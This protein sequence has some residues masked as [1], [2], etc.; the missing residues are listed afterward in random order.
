MRRLR[1]VAGLTRER[2]S[3]QTG[4]NAVTLYRIETGHARPQ[5]RTLTAMLDVYDLTDEQRANLIDLCKEATTHD[6]IALYRDELSNAYSAFISFE[7]EASAH[8]NYESLFLPGLLQTEDYARTLMQQT[9]RGLPTANA[10]EIRVKARMTRQML[11]TKDNPMSLWSVVDEAAMR[12]VV[13]G[14]TVM[15][16]QLVHL[17]SAIT[18]PHI[19]FQVI[20][21]RIGAHPGMAGQFALLEFADIEDPDLVYVDTLA[22]DLFVEKAEEVKSYRAMFE[23]LVAVAL[24]PAESATMVNE[25]ANDLDG[26]GA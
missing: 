1:S 16:D 12:R 21:F 23:Q 8:R 7:S 25:I 15:R 9:Q 19:T 18:A 5:L 6:W 11:L 24:S 22:G 26:R 13:G 4:I 14:P 17:A 10:V 3:D 2:V 20:P